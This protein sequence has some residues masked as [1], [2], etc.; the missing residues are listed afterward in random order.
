MHRFLLFF[1]IQFSFFVNAQDTIIHFSIDTIKGKTGITFDTI[2]KYDTVYYNGLLLEASF[3]GNTEDVLQAL[4]KGADA[5]TKTPEGVTPLM[6]A[7]QNGF[8]DI[9]KILVHNGANVNAIPDD[10]ATALIA[11]TRFNHYEVMDHLIQSGANINLKDRDSV[12]ALLYAAAYGYF[13]P[14][15]LLIFYGADINSCTDDS[16][17][18][19][20]VAAFNNNYDVAELLISKG[21]NVNGADKKKWTPLMA[22][23]FKGNTK[24]T[25]QLIIKGANLNALNIEGY[26]ALAIATEKN[27]PEIFAL[28]LANGADPNIGVSTISL[29][30]LALHYDSYD[31]Y[32]QLQKGKAK[33]EILPFFD[34][35]RFAP[36]EIIM[37]TKDFMWGIKAG[38]N[39]KRYRTTLSFGYNTRFWPNRV[40]VDKGNNVFFQFRERRSMLYLSAEKA[41]PV[42]RFKDIERNVFIDLREAYTYGRYRAST[43]EPDDK[44]IFFP[45]VGY[46]ASNSSA[47]FKIALGYYK[48]GVIDEST[49]HI[50]SGVYFKIPLHKY[51]SIQKQ[52]KWL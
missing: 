40:L 49:L 42:Y 47:G 22:A 48:T 2:V 13:I 11:A 37:N 24:I 15:D 21:A 5:N 52:I 46:G 38:I 3:N 34:N 41:F 39:D 4:L 29:K 28:L 16:T 51:P 27:Y 31:I 18:A 8:L 43:S 50:T 33:K 23:V 32:K 25:E 12:S 35:I 45:S 1:L 26:T 20:Y 44:F 17:N 30:K 7:A 10:G 14:A 19:L 9:V 36:A 6:F